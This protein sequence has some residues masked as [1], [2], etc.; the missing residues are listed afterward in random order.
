MQD[1]IDHNSPRG[2]YLYPFGLLRVKVEN[3]YFY[4]LKYKKC[5]LYI[6][7]ANIYERLEFYAEN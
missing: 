4:Y 2:I 6:I 3:L 5:R 1:K 7:S